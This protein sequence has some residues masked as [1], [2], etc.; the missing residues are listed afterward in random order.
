MAIFLDTGF[1]LG[2]IHKKDPH[3]QKA[4]DWLLQIRQ[5]LY[6]QIYTSNYILSEAVTLVA[7]RT[8]GNPI[9]LT[10]LRQIFSGSL[11]IAT[12]LR[13]SEEEDFDAWD[14]F[15]KLATT[16]ELVYEE[17]F[18]SFVD[19]TNIVLCQQHSIEYIAS[20]D[21]HFKGWLE[22]PY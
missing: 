14:L 22:S 8:D 16:G 5:G 19:C 15:D 20:F 13:V 1:Y 10:R 17:G 18:V 6:G 3:Y 9:A 4:Q 11:Q 12:L 7:T 2:L 21:A